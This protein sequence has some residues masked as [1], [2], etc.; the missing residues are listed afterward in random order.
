MDKVRVRPLRPHEKKKLLRLKRQKTNAVNSRHAR[1]VLL[2]RGG[3]GNRDIAARADCSPQWVRV[4]IHRFNQDGL[5]G[6][7]WFPWMHA[8]GGPRRFKADVREQ[9]AEI[10]LASPKALI[11]LTC[12]SLSKLRDYL[13]EQGIVASISCAWLGTLLRRRGVRWRRTKTWKESADPQFW[14]KYQRLRRLYRGCPKGGRRICVDEFGPLNLLPR[15]GRCLA[16]RGKGVERHRATYSRKGGV[17][18]FLAAYDL[19]TD[20]L[21]GQFHARK[22][23]VQFLEFLRWLR[24][25]YPSGQ[26]LHVV[27]DNYGPHLKVEVATWAWANRVRLYYTPTNASW[28]NRIECQFTALKEFALGNSDHRSHEDLQEAI[29][30]YVKWRNGDRPLSI[31]NW[32]E[33]KRQQASLH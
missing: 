6:I 33:F 4:V 13:V 5:F 7:L 3:L 30:L 27:L 1:I 25:R 19:E 17:R 2:S 22:T 8:A 18:H 28:L 32:R 26:T 21:L 16:G 12:W 29:E 31:Q 20:K 11:G 14:C 23:W 24:G 15:A 9:I 10:A